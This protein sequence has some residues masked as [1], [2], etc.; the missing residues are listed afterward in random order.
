MP[1]IFQTITGGFFDSINH[2]RLYS[3]EQMNMPYKKLITDGI[4]LNEN[5]TG[6]PF[7]VTAAGGMIVNIGAGNA[8]IGGKWAENEETMAVEISGNTS[9]AARIDSIILRLD[10]S[11]G[12]RAVGIVYRQ[13]AATAPALET[14]AYVK[15]FRL[16]NITVANNAA[17]ITAANITDTRGGSECPYVTSI[18]DPPEARYIIEEY[19]GSELAGSHQTVKS[20]INSIRYAAQSGQPTV[21]M[22]AAD[23]TEHDKVYLYEGSED[24]YDAGYLYYYSATDSA[25]IRGAQYGTSVVDT[26]LDADSE[27]PVQNK[28]V[29]AAITGLN[30]RLEE[31]EQSG[32]SGA[33]VPTEV[34]Q[35]I[36]T[37]LT[38]GL[39]SDTGLTDEKAVLQS[40]ATEVTEVTI[41]QSAISISGAA[42]SQLTATTSPAGGLV[43]WS[44]SNP[45]V[46]TVSSNGLVT[47]VSNGTATITASCGGKTATCT[48]TVTGFATLTGITATYTQSGTVYDTDSI[49]NLKSDLV[50]VASYDNSTTR[51]LS[52]SE[53]TLSGTLS[54]GTSTITVSY[55]GQTDTFS[56]TVTH[57]DMPLYSWNLTASL[58]DTVENVT[59]TTT[60]TYT[61]GTG[62]VFD[63]AQ[64]YINFGQ[65]YGRDRTYEI[66]VASFGSPRSTAHRRLITFDTDANTSSGGAGLTYR[67]GYGWY[68]YT[69]STWD[70]KLTGTDGETLFDGKTVKLYLDADGMATV[71]YKTIGADD[72]T[73][74][75]LGESTAAMNDFTNGL[76]INGGS[77]S[78]SLSEATIS[79]LRIYEGEK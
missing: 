5:E 50:V 16:A 70:T 34:R 20:A 47:G 69:G 39:Y 4:I 29:T 67:K 3:A 48:A 62:V 63:G 33:D 73:Y 71:Y 17:A 55:G 27:N 11:I 14:S 54:A 41:S 31:L 37:L 56:V 9:G 46:A 2:D 77:T 43:T 24:G 42:T 45:A 36:Y 53:Y 26:D 44:S 65:V 49:S 25:W 35:A 1:D 75:K 22:Q 59:A 72:S 78:D 10:K 23:M 19:N 38:K 7:E 64:K 12:T 76:V 21:A 57:I 60:A 30:G 74:T 6:S 79:G 61:Q 13:G 68:L 18:F 28:A 51:T 15:E 52:A 32:G 40:W 8:L 58:T 66:D